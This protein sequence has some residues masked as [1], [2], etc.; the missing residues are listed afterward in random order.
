MRV[1]VSGA[2][3]F[4][5]SAIC[6]RLRE[7]GDTVE[8]LVRG[9]ADGV[10]W[11]P[12]TGRFDPAAAEGADAVV[13]LAG[14]SVFSGRLNEKRK[15]AIRDSRVTGTRLLAEGLARLERPPRVIACASATGFYGDG[16]DAEQNEAS[17][18]GR[19]FLAEVC[20][21]WESACA[22]AAE[23]GI[24][25]ANLRIGL[26][27]STEGGALGKMLPV[28]RLGLGGRVGD[29]RQWM[30]WI[31]LGDLVR[32]VEWVLFDDA[33]AGAVNAVA[34]HPVRNDEFTHALARVLR[35]PAVLPVPAIVLRLALGE[36][37]DELLLSGTRAVPKRLSERGFRFEH[38]QIEPALRALLED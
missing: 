3:G 10:L 15:A 25:V 14:E 19:G 22:P 26:V 30:S 23:R 6:R 4:V 2:S 5:G 12:T 18:V 1:L 29:G 33:L 32:V 20:R 27:L 11:D 7:R 37:A 38:A 21:D 16:G 13:H 17:P 36:M 31:T 35:R 28:F 34:P 24:R 8:R 9:A